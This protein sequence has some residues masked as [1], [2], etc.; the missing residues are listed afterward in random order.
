M[1][2][3]F[4]GLHNIP[5]SNNSIQ[6]WQCNK[7]I[8]APPIAILIQWLRIVFIPDITDNPLIVPLIENGPLALWQNCLVF[9][10]IVCIGYY[11]FVIPQQV[12]IFLLPP[13]CLHR[14]LGRRRTVMSRLHLDGIVHAQPIRS[15]QRPDALLPVVAATR[16]WDQFRFLLHSQFY[17]PIL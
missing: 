15:V 9:G 1:M 8:R 16:I 14:G 4:L 3:P 2:L 11:I 5:G 10:I 17:W 7:S 6:M 13:Y 12:G